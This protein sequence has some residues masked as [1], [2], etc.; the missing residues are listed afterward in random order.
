M[1]SSI[2]VTLL[3]IVNILVGC[4]DSHPK[5]DMVIF[6]GNIYTNIEKEPKAEAI[7]IQNGEIIYVGNNVNANAWVGD[8]TTVLDIQGN[9]L[10]P[11][12]IEGHGHLMNLGYSIQNLNLSKAKNL[13]EIATQVKEKAQNTKKGE[14]I[15]GRGWHQDKWD[16][17]Y[18]H[19]IKGF[20]TNDSLSSATADHPVVLTHASGHMILVNDKA[21]ELAGITSKTVVPEG[22][23]IIIDKKGKLTGLLNETAAQLIYDIIP[24][25]SDE[26]KI[27]ALNLAIEECL[28][29]GITSFHDAGVLVDQAI[30]N[31]YESFFKN[32]M[33]KI[34]VYAMLDGTNQELLDY[35]FDRGPMISDYLTVRSI[36]LRADGALGSRG[37][38]LI[39]DYEDADSVF[40][41]RVQPLELIMNTTSKAYEKG[42]QIC[43]HCIGD[44]SNKEILDIYEIVMKSDTTKENPRFRIEHAQHLAKEDISR[45][46]KLG[47]IPSMQAIHL[48]SDRPWAIHRLGLDR[49]E[50]GA[51]AWRSLIDSGAMVMNGTDVPV[52]PI[53][54]IANYYSSVTRKTLNGTPEGGF[55]AKQKMTRKE[56]LMAYTYNNAYGA[57]E[58]VK[59][60][61][62]KKGNLADFTVLS[63]DILKIPEDKILDTEILYTIINGKVVYMK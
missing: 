37:A 53:N 63:Q 39:E 62:I 55:E 4:G 2:I 20:P 16:S 60:G 38:L 26:Q 33:L 19:K 34:R 61:C 48:S 47:V 25:P 24:E 51:Y 6:N 1:K 15:I 11:G 5:A 23:E 45:F 9:T 35:W 44:R 18:F 8:S 17:S 7:A 49:I 22:G 57:F 14:W 58:E 13:N 59:K 29:N 50:E 46:G 43:T 28:K 42:F 3:L 52:E 30:I 56:A 54:P 32:N 36:K 21:L 10:I 40:G 27:E 12:L 31:L 41:Q